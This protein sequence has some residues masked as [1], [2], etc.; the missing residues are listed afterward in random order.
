MICVFCQQ[1]EMNTEDHGAPAWSELLGEDP[2]R[3]EWEIL[4]QKPIL[5]AADI[6]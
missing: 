5:Q 3:L 1:A 6:V 2:L 4:Q